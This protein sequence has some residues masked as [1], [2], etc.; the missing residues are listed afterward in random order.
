MLAVT[1]PVRPQLASELLLLLPSTVQGLSGTVLRAL[2]FLFAR[3]E[4]SVEVE[5]GG[6]TLLYRHRNGV[7]PKYRVGQ[8]HL[9]RVRKSEDLDVFVSENHDVRLGVVHRAFRIT[10]RFDPDL[11]SSAGQPLGHR[12]DE[13]VELGADDKEEETS[14]RHEDLI[15]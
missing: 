13:V 7:S 3:T 14:W 8:Q 2:N 1:P 9:D 6:V 10:G 5:I 15:G 11:V 4:I 12:H